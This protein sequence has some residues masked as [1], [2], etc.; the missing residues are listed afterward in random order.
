MPSPQAGRVS[1]GWI[2]H[3][4][5]LLFKMNLKQNS[6]SIKVHD[7]EMLLLPQ[8]A[9]YFVKEKILL[10]S[11]LHIGKTGHFRDAGIPV[12]SEL[13]FADLETLDKIFSELEVERFIILGD[14]FHAK[15]N[16]DWRILA[17]WRE[18]YDLLQIQLVKGNHDILKES[19]YKEL[20]VEVYD[21]IIFKNFLLV[22]NLGHAGNDNDL[23]KIC[24]HVHPA[25]RLYSKGRQAATL[26][27]YYFGDSFAILPAFGR[28]TGKFTISPKENHGVFVIAGAGEDKR[29]MKI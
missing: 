8:K 19:V 28:F 11:D 18:R 15:L 13:A 12:P 16:I 14:L 25:V 10:A 23:Y 9:V 5:F 21:A 1:D 4:R 29:V 17:G 7:V 20:N 6:I 2:C 26:P 27:C 24:G 22:H 3:R